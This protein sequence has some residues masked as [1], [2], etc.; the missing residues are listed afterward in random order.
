MWVIK[1]YI[2]TSQSMVFCPLQNIMR[3]VA[4]ALVTSV[5]GS[6]G[7]G[8]LRR[9][10]NSWI[11]IDKDGNTVSAGEVKQAA[12]PAKPKDVASINGEAGIKRVTNLALI[13]PA[14]ESPTGTKTDPSY[15][16]IHPRG[17]DVS[18]LAYGGYTP[19]PED[20][21]KISSLI[22]GGDTP[23]PKDYGRQ[24][25]G[26]DTPPSKSDNDDIY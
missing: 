18:K 16:D 4:F 26:G 14:S 20:Y 19:P 7:K 22:W 1:E 17:A 5:C 21:R 9:G 12:I 13:N 23:P 2:Y 25:W 11:K 24:I 15:F 3:I 6:A 10:D 8:K